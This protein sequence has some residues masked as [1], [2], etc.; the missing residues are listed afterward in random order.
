MEII[1]TLN[2]SKEY[3]HIVETVERCIQCG[4]RIFRVNL[5]KCITKEERKEQVGKMVK[6]KR[7]HGICIMLDL[8]YPYTKA[9][10][11]LKNKNMLNLVKSDKV[12]IGKGENCLATFQPD[13]AKN[14]CVGE[15]LY[16]SDMEYPFQIT[17]VQ[18]ECIEIMALDDACIHDKK[19]IYGKGLLFDNKNEVNDLLAAAKEIKPEYIA[20]SFLQDVNSANDFIDQYE[21][22]VAYVAKIETQESMD[23]IEKIS[24]RFHLMVARGDLIHFA[25]RYSLLKNQ[26]QIINN[27][28]KE[29]KKCYVATGIMESYSKQNMLSQAELCDLYNIMNAGVDGVVLNY[30]VIQNNAH[31]AVDSINGYTEV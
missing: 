13:I 1:A 28:L 19:G 15:Y 31:R 25:S 11:F 16:L 21:E 7:Q 3:S 12:L 4:I 5:S 17:S 29:N 20:F 18:G 2:T 22:A 26:N 9:R 6:L 8:P 27:A 10:I 14:I 24:K 23:N 30:G